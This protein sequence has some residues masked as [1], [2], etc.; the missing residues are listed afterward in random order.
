MKKSLIIAIT[1]ATIY[2][3]ATAQVNMPAPSPTQTIIQDFGLGKIELTYSRP[4]LK[5]RQ[6]FG[7]N[8]ELVPLGKPWRTGANAATKIHF[9]DKV[10]VGGKDLDSGSYVIYTIPGKENWDIVLS[11]GNAYP[12]QEGFTA[13]D[14]ILHYKA[15][16]VL[17]K[18]KIET[19]TMQ[20]TDLKNERCQLHLK[21]ANTDV[22]IPIT[23]N[24]KERI[25]QEIE[26]ALQ[27][28]NPPYYQAANFYYE[29]DKNYQKAL[30]YIS[31]ATEQNPKAYFMYLQKARIQQA[32]GDKKGARESG[33]KT[34]ELAKE[35]GN[36]DYVNF[37]NKLL[38]Q[39]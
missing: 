8:S 23:T 11:K 5:G 14:D 7:N 16:V 9:T 3:P 25:R 12:G 6:V 30:E 36:A 1:I 31:K 10:N 39:L 32:L 35:A 17:H 33:I 20:F 28:N 26:T 15:P 38:Q 22:A 37:G 4:G 19:F 24:I 2:F 27:G 18:Q 21:W 29:Y 34:I 13:N